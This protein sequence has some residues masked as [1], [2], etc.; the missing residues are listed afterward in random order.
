MKTLSRFL[1]LA[2]LSSSKTSFELPF[3]SLFLSCDRKSPD[4]VGSGSCDW[5]VVV[6][7]EER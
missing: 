6:S 1:R 7:V 2:F 4:S 5:N 3:Y